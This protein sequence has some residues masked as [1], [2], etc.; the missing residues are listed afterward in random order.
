MRCLNFLF[1]NKILISKKLTFPF[2]NYL[3]YINFLKTFLSFSPL[4]V[5]KP[6]QLILKYVLATCAFK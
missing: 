1:K 4:I 5:E 3:F 6:N 2:I